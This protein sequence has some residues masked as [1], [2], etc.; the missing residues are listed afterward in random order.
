MLLFTIIKKLNIKVLKKFIRNISSLK[1]SLLKK[2]NI[3]AK[4]INVISKIFLIFIFLNFKFKVYCLK[5]LSNILF[6]LKVSYHPKVSSQ[7]GAEVAIPII[8][9]PAPKINVFIFFLRVVVKLKR[10]FF[11][12]KI[13]FLIG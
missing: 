13:I 2:L 6:F 4:S 5:F 1:G 3:V 11:L 8:P 7:P 9:I 10:A 12:T